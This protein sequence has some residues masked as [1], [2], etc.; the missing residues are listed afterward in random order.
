M[1]LVISCPCG[2]TVRAETEDELVAQATK[3]VK[4]V[5][6]QEATREQ[7]LAMATKE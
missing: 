3:H 5:H 4:E 7:L 1:A 2:H 6:K